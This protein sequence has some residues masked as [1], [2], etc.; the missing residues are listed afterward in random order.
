MIN[1][2]LGLQIWR[3][4]IQGTH[5]LPLQPGGGCPGR[6]HRSGAGIGGQGAQGLRLPCCGP[7]HLPSDPGPEGLSGWYPGRSRNLLGADPASVRSPAQNP[8]RG[9]LEALQSQQG[10]ARCAE[11]SITSPLPCLGR[12]SAPT[13]CLSPHLQRGHG[14]GP[15][16][17]FPR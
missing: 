5:Q 4:L 8:L 3:P 16:R 9:L 6:G 1:R 10:L 14:L 15:G 2:A 12:R 17:S 13:P 11:T 7:H